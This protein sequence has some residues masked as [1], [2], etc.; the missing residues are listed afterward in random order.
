MVNI[1]KISIFVIHS[2]DESYLESLGHFNCINTNR[3]VFVGLAIESARLIDDLDG[4]FDY[5]TYKITDYIEIDNIEVLEP[6]MDYC[7]INYTIDGI[8]DIILDE[9]LD[10]TR[11]LYLESVLYYKSNQEGKKLNNVNINIKHFDDFIHQHSEDILTYVVNQ[12]NEDFSETRVVIETYLTNEE[13]LLKFGKFL[14]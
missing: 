14:M 10:D 13:A 3:N 6:I 11:K 4:I 5:E 1:N 8:L 7:G 9:T 2:Q 12:N